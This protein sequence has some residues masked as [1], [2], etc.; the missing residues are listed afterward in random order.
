MKFT[1]GIKV[2]LLLVAAC[3]FLGCGQ[4]KE[5]AETAKSPAPQAKQRATNATEPVVS[6]KDKS[7]TFSAATRVCTLMQADDFATVY[8][9][10]TDAFKK[11]GGESQ[12]VSFMKGRGQKIGL[13]K[14][15]EE[16]DFHPGNNAE[17]GKIFSVKCNLKF[18][19]ADQT[20]IFTFSRTKDGKMKLLSIHQLKD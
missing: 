7:E 1:R 13:L 10:S 3:S 20:Q 19:K 12:F 4:K 17:L 5:A 14:T 18:A 16:S 8:K 15:F 2:F 6:S 11:S 9:E